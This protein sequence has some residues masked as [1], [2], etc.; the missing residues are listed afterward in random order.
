M[1]E[2]KGIEPMTSTM[3]LAAGRFVQASWRSG[4]ECN[5]GRQ[6]VQERALANTTKC[7]QARAHGRKPNHS[8]FSIVLT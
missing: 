7:E 4:F 1:V 3:P 5:L 8:D 2:C 6:H